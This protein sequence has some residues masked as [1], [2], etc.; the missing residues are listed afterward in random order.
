MLKCSDLTGRRTGHVVRVGK[1]TYRISVKYLKG[2]R[3][4]LILDQDMIIWMRGIYLSKAKMVITIF[5]HVHEK[6][7]QRAGRVRISV[8]LSIR[9]QVSNP[10]LLKSFWW[11]LAWT[12]GHWGYPKLQWFNFQQSAL[13]EN[14]WDGEI[15]KM[16]DV[17]TA[18]GLHKNCKFCYSILKL[19]GGWGLRLRLVKNSYLVVCIQLY[20]RYG[21]L[22]SHRLLRIEF[23]NS[24]TYVT[25]KSPYEYNVEVLWHRIWAQ[26]ITMFA[27]FVTKIASKS[28]I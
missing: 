9:P 15:P 16:Y 3:C 20:L 7:A 19:F 1:M 10:E 26:T 27:T 24:E 8:C 28:T 6:K 12:L 25:N 5:V 4:E 23:I 18:T 21:C 17:W 2:L 13:S 11:T 22:G 14:L